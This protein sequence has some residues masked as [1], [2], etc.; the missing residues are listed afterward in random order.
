L[1]QAMSWVSVWSLFR[2]LEADHDR[3]KVLDR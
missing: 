1:I 3:R 2:V